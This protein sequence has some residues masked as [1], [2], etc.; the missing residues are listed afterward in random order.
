M[1][2]FNWR[3]EFSIGIKEMD[4]QHMELVSIINGI[5]KALSEGQG[6]E[7]LGDMLDR[8]LKYTDNHFAAEEKLLKN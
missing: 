5:H 3:K 4:N 7:R 8:L 6:M 1:S 2:N